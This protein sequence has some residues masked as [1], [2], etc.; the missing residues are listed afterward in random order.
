MTRSASEIL[1]NS[2]VATAS[3]APG[4]YYA[5][6]PECSRKR[7]QSHQL[8]KC[9]GITIDERGVQFG[10]NHCGW[11][12]G[13]FYENAGTDRHRGV[14]APERADPA[15]IEI[16][17]AKAKE[18]QR[19]EAAESQEKVSWLWSQR[20]PPAGTVVETYLR[21]CRGYRGRLPATLGFVPGRGEY[22]P[23]MIAAFGIARETSPGEI[24]IDDAAVTGIHITK[25][26][27]DGSDKA[28]TEADKLTIG[29]ANKSPIILAP[30]NDLLGLA[31]AEGIEDALSAHAATGLGA[32]AAGTAGRLPAV[33]EFVPDYIE[34]VTIMVD[35]DPNGEKNSAE[36]ARRLIARG[37]EVL[38]ARPGGIA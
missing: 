11:T 23:A 22:P 10:C 34:S 20:T 26:R 13:E 18:R 27:P 35:A 28:G 25:L 16:A 8:L 1:R 4:R 15:T 17:T 36:L 9:L 12:G 7:K 30:P 3:S 29:I 24:V 33:A 31:V 6:C 21:E 5:I 38:M 14:R 37:I 32:W 19:L 2:R